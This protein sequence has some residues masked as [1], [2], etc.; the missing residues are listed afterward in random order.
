MTEWNL[1]I[2]WCTA[3]A[4]TAQKNDF[5]WLSD[6][7]SLQ[8]MQQIFK[9]NHK[10]SSW[11]PIDPFQVST[12]KFKCQPDIS[13]LIAPDNAKPT[14]KKAKFIVT[15]LRLDMI[16]GKHF[17]YIQNMKVQES[18]FPCDWKAMP[19]ECYKHGFPPT[20]LDKPPSSKILWDT[21]GWILRNGMTTS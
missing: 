21:C 14:K 8:E 9:K 4:T 5:P 18:I 3:L 7:D 13:Y 1:L 6:N 19:G 12:A 11:L 17:R 2:S 15:Q 10:T 16:N 20:R